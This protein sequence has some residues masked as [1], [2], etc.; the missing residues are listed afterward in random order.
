[1]SPQEERLAIVPISFAEAK[2]SVARLHRHLPHVVGHKFSVAVAAGEAIVGVAIVGRPVAR[3]LD[4]GWTLEVVRLATDGAR[5][6]C[7]M[8]YGTSWRAARAMGYRRITTY[9]RS[10]EPGTSLRA[11]GWRTVAEVAPGSWNRASRPR[12]DQTPL[13][14]KCRWEPEPTRSQEAS[15]STGEEGA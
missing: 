10:E 3:H 14:G 4:D 12:V 9:T 5:N 13:Q 11:A 7:S 6:A 2:A 1:V 8:L 15:P